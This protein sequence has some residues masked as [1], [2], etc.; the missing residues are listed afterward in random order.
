[1]EDVHLCALDSLLNDLSYKSPKDFAESIDELLSINLL[2]CPA[3][4]RY[5]EV[6]V[7]RDIFIHN[8]GIA[9]DVYVRKAASHVRVRSGMALPADTVYFLESYEYLLAVLR[10]ARG[11]ATRQVAQFRFGGPKEE[12]AR[13]EA[14]RGGRLE[15]R[16]ITS[17]SSGTATR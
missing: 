2:E 6:K 16:R 1:L 12:E 4:H 3:F 17:R 5:M 13:N 8:R 15:W 14:S 10:M 7:S 9:N 11:T